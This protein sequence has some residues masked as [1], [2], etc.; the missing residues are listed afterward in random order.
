M[1][2]RSKTQLLLRDVRWPSFCSAA[3]RPAPAAERCSSALPPPERGG[4]PGVVIL[5]FVT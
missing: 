4:D 3:C 1:R 5:S 2:I